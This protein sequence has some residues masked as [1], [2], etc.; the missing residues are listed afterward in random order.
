MPKIQAPSQEKANQNQTEPQLFIA[1]VLG[2]IVGV[3]SGLIGMA[4]SILVIGILRLFLPN[5][6]FQLAG[7]SITAVIFVLFCAIGWAAGTLFFWK[8]RSR[9]TN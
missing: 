1:L 3:F 9:S 7:I 6:T 4:L 8:K 2:A 5:L